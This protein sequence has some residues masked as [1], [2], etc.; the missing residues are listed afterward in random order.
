MPDLI[1]G[2]V[3]CDASDFMHALNL[4]IPRLNERPNME[5]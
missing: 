5:S 4:V 2:D 3:D 1:Q